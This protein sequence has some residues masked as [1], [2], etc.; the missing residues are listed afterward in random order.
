MRCEV[1]QAENSTCEEK[2]Q[3]FLAKSCQVQGIARAVLRILGR[4]NARLPGHRDAGM[5][6]YDTFQVRPI[7]DSRSNLSILIAYILK[8]A[9]SC[10]RPSTFTRLQAQFSHLNWISIRSNIATLSDLVAA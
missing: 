10:R 2:Q 9:T 4:R 7:V 5:R 6:T 3:T 8:E 1:D